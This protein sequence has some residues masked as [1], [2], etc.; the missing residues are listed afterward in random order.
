MIEVTRLYRK[1]SKDKKT[2]EAVKTQ[3]MLVAK[4]SVESVRPSTALGT[5]HKATIVT[6]SGMEIPV[7]ETRSELQTALGARVVK[8]K[9]TTPARRR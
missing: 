8:A 2:T 4:A 7:A 1:K 9:T 5:K 6:V 3:T